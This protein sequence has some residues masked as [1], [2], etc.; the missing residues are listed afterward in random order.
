MPRGF[1]MDWLVVRGLARDDYGAEASFELSV[2]SL[3]ENGD[4][5]DETDLGRY[6]DDY[7][8]YGFMADVREGD[9]EF[10]SPAKAGEID[11]RKT[12]DDSM[13]EFEFG[14]W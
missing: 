13:G 7:P 1:S 4:S 14:H 8:D 3:A 11:E 10:G 9:D 2:E 5:G 12:K 6:E